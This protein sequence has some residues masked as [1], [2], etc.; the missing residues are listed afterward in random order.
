M[1]IEDPLLVSTAHPTSMN[2][3]E[4]KFSNTNKNSTISSVI[5][6]D[7]NSA[8]IYTRNTLASAMNPFDKNPKIESIVILEDD[9]LLT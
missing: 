7:F 4:G 1:L 5:K 3:R 9:D 8:P 6:L 2:I